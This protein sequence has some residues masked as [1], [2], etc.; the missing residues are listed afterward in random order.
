M[1]AI[2][3]YY[4]KL[5]FYCTFEQF[6]NKI[7]FMKKLQHLK[8]L[9]NFFLIGLIINSLSRIILFFIFKERV[10]ETENY[11]QLFLIGLRFDVIL[12][13]YLAFLPFVLITFLPDNWLQKIKNFFTVY[14]IF[15]LFIMLLMELS[16]PDFVRNNF[17]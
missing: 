8:P 10:I 5:I 7:S 12:L 15:F 6:F 1:Y 2:R 9:F 3:S 14:F 13:S 4:A 17:V 16:T 11:N